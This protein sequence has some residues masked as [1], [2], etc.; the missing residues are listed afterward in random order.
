LS[1]KWR[2]YK[3][4]SNR[5]NIFKG[6]GDEVDRQANKGS[7]PIIRFCKAGRY[8]PSH[9]WSHRRRRWRDP[10]PLIDIFEE[11][12]KTTVVA[13]LAGFK[14]EHLRIGVE[15]QRLTLA[16]EAPGR[17]YYK[18]LNLKRRVVPEMLQMSY[19][20]GVLQIQLRR[21]RGQESVNKVV[22]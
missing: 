18:S 12:D 15:D 8:R 14:R 3:K 10:E 1:A 22:G 20:N 5:P 2:R 7:Y 13:E 16:A 21:A 4:R 6:F 17:N 19:R 11:D 9:L